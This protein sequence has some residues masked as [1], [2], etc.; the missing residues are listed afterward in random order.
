ML[1]LGKDVGGLR[2]LD[3][4][5]LLHHHHAVAI[6]G[7]QAEIMRDQDRR[8]AALLG[9]LDDQVHDGL[10]RGDVEAGGRLVRDQEL[11][12]A[13]ER[14]RDHDALAHAAGQLERIGMIALARDA[15][16]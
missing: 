13:G 6:G 8:H 7:G 12:I 5:A 4:A 2:G 15:R 9:E 10:L 11:R 16:S 1:G 14:Q 3:H